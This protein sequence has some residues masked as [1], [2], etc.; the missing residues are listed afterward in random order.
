VARD[1]S[2]ILDAVSE[3][4]RRALAIASDLSGFASAEEPPVPAS[5]ATSDAAHAR[6]PAHLAALIDSTLTL[7]TGNLADV[8]VVRDYDEELPAIAVE[9]G[10]LGQV[11]LNL[12]LNAT[13]AMRGSGTLT[14]STRRL[15]QV[16]EL[17]VADTG[18]GIA[19][20][21]LPRI[22]EPFFSTKGPTTGTGLG[23]SISYAIVKRHGGRIL[24][25]STV[26]VGTT[27]RVQLPLG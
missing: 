12:I 17:A 23:L 16:A 22:F 15:D 11:I 4:A 26:G 18:P 7:V 1:L 27:F 3:G 5:V 19:K 13:Q 2:P 6:R 24:V 8:A 20:D 10:P 21:V 14:L 9:T 25:E